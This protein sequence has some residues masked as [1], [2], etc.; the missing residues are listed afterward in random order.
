MHLVNKTNYNDKIKDI[1]DKIPSIKNLAATAAF[2]AVER[3]IPNVSNIVKKVDYSA[4]ILDIES[5]YFTMSDYHKFRND[6]FDAK[7]KNKKLVNKCDIY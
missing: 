4:K 3:K 5:K 7:V 6:I 2:T 1:E